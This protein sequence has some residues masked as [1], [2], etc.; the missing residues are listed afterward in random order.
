MA[1]GTTYGCGFELQVTAGGALTS[2]TVVV[3]GSRTVSVY[4]GL[5]AAASGDQVTVVTGNLNVE[6]PALS[7]D[8]WA[9][10]AALYWDV[11]N[12]RL[13]DTATDNLPCGTA[14]AAKAASA[15]TA[16]LLLNENNGP[17]VTS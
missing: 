3:L 10:G 4:T 9:V 14:A 2:G 5:K 7:T 8:D 15:T 12:A 11:S 16:R 17:V 1:T 13:T 6:L